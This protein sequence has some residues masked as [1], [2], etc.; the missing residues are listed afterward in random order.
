MDEDSYLELLALISPLIK[1][2]DTQMRSA[3]TPH[4]KLTATLRFLATGRTYENLKFTT[5]ISPQALG[6]IIPETCEAL[7][8]VLKTDYLTVK[9]TK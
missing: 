6:R 5:I 9:K 4:E 3:I 8:S 2:S 7:Y 1:K